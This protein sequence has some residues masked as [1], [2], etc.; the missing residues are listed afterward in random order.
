MSVN[1]SPIGG[2]AGQFFDNNGQP[3]SGGKIYTYA[4]GTTTPQ[5]TYTSALGI[6][7][8]ANPIVLDS[9]GRVPGGEIWLTDG[10]IYKFVVE[11]SAAILI[12]TYDNITG[13]NSN[14]VNYTVQEEV[15]TATSGQT[16]FTLTTINYTPGTNSLSVYVD[17]VNQ[18]V[19][20]SYLETDSTTVTFTS[21]LHVGAEVKFTTAVQTTTGAVDAN[22]VGYTANFTGAVGQT[23]QTKLE[24]YVSVKDFGAVGDGVADDTAAIQ[25]ALSSGALFVTIPESATDYRISDTIDIPT[26]V[27]LSGYGASVRALSAKTGNLDT[28]GRH[29]SLDT[30]SRLLGVK[31]KPADG[32]YTFNPSAYHQ[33]VAMSG[34]TPLVR[35]LHIDTTGSLAADFLS[36][37]QVMTGT[38]GAII[39]SCISVDGAIRYGTGSA[40]S[41]LVKN[42]EVY[43]AINDAMTANGDV[44][45][46]YYG[47]IIDGFYIEDPARM[48]IEDYSR[49][50]NSPQEILSGS[51]IQ[52]GKIVCTGAVTPLYFAV[53]AVSMMPRINNVHIVNW[54]HDYAIE[55]MGGC[56][57][58]VSN[59][60]VEWT[61]G[62]PNNVRAVQ[63]QNNTGTF[64]YGVTV[65]NNLFIRAYE[66]ILARSGKLIAANN[67]FVD[68]KQY[69]I[70][71]EVAETGRGNQIVGNRFVAK[72]P[73]TTTRIMINAQNQSVITGNFIEYQASATGGSAQEWAI[74]CGGSNSVIIGNYTQDDGVTSGASAPYFV[75]TNGSTPSNVR[76]IGNNC[77]GSTRIN[78]QYFV[79]LIA[80]YNVIPGT[81]TGATNV[82]LGFFNKTPVRASGWTAPT[83]TATRTTFDTATVTTTQL[84]ERVKAL[85]DD[86]YTTSGY[87]L[88]QS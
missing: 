2:Y 20:T 51:V 88:L 85:I 52:N 42:V 81:V 14:F 43:N 16:V 24:Q 56:G 83:G 41:T 31:I 36:S 86:L 44:A 49:Q 21:G 28:L 76:I 84:A 9:A 46:I 71:D 5:A 3:L 38:V 53:S 1:P 17:G 59:C 10:L 58:S 60:T 65:E 22:N 68:P 67:T 48:G 64:G 37:I 54:P 57:A 80:E 27:T 35:D 11:T 7:P 77:T 25:A 66:G 30:D 79:N 47:H 4:A 63:I 12:G 19:G 8:H 73:N 82:K 75:L 23:V 74:L 40:T 50:F 33:I 62:N 70:N 6:T 29:F 15:Q 55:L 18:Y 69:G 72:S 45:G 78:Y 26:G 39:E 61:D 32:S 13:V 87:G 34:T